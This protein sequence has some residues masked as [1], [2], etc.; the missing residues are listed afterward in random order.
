MK[1]KWKMAFFTLLGIVVIVLVLTG[2]FFFS[3]LAIGGKT[4]NIPNDV[5]NNSQPIFTVQADK[6]QLDH[7]INNEIQRHQTGN[8]NYS[9]NMDND[10][11]VNGSLGVL[12]TSMPF[13]IAFNPVV[14]NGDVILKEKT[15]KL[16]KFNLPDKQVLK[17]IN[18]GT[19]LPDWVIVQP[20]KR[21]I[22]INV[23]KI[24]LN[25]DIDFYLKAKQI[26]LSSNKIIF[27]L[28]QKS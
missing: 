13:S 16:G 14:E 27:E 2:V 11:R 6:E 1:N 15:V 5:K 12:G 18:F 28:H 26:Q 19:K 8:L 4:Q 20:D 23:T 17:F 3:F 7:L 21:Q 22:Y 9:V 25:K 24:P 10:V